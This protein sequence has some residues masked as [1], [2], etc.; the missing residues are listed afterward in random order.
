MAR[1]TRKTNLEVVPLEGKMLLSGM[2]AAVP[3]GHVEM[4]ATPRRP[5]AN[6]FQLSGNLSGTVTYA[7]GVAALT[8]VSGSIGRSPVQGYGFIQLGA[9]GISGQGALVLVGARNSTV[10]VVMQGAL[11]AQG[12]LNLVMGSLQ[13]TGQ[14]ARSAGHYALGQVQ[15]S[16]TSPT[17]GQFIV[18]FTPYG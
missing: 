5:R 18:G 16:L 6:A 9:D 17:S 2:S 1:Q 15:F 7:N 8:G 4:M 13:G 3:H 11:D 10:T 14:F 12:H